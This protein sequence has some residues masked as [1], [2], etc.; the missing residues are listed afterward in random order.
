MID[1]K[2]HFERL[3]AALGVKNPLTCMNCADTIDAQLWRD[4]VMKA[5]DEISI[6]SADEL[7]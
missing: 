3:Q 5:I 4:E 7:Q 6:E 1:F 2:K